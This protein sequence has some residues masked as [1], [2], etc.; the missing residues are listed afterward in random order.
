MWYDEG[1]S[2]FG[3]KAVL[4]MCD[5]PYQLYELNHTIR[6]ALEEPHEERRW[7]NGEDIFKDIMQDNPKG[8]TGLSSDDFQLALVHAAKR[9]PMEIEIFSLS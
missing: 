3:R 9:N 5:L 1:P 2:C 7:I 4:K 6:V 8:D